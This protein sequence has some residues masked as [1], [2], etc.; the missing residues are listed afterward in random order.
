MKYLI[1]SA[2]DFGLT[3]SLNEGIVKSYKE[4]IVRSINF[5]PSGAAFKDAEQR[6]HDLNPDGL[7]AHLSLTESSPVTDPSKIPSLVTKNGLFF[8]NRVD[9]FIRFFTKKVNINEVYLE[10]K[11]QIDILKKT[12]IPI[13]NLSSHEHIHMASGILNIFIRLA[14]EHGIPSIRYPHSE[15]GAGRFN[16]RR[17]FKSVILR[18]FDAKMK[19][20]LDNAN[21]AYP[22][23]FRGFLDSGRIDEEIL[24]DMSKHLEEGATELVSHPGFLG[25]EI[26]DNYPFHVNCERE[27]YALTSPRV[28]KSL[29]ENNIEM[30]SYAKFLAG[31]WQTK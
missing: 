7:G 16:I 14:K 17:C 8:K 11:G 30:I 4:G 31:K 27:L 3:K 6:L 22:D 24:I 20:S 1:A 26:L 2:D 10:L 13:T 9:F 5:M 28:K 19:V 25:P 12:G 23:H 21:M 18:Y 29:K 15:N